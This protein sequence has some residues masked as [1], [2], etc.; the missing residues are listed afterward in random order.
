VLDA[1][2]TAVFTSATMT[3]AHPNPNLD[4]TVPNG[5]VGRSV[6]LEFSGLETAHFTGGIAEFS[7]T[8]KR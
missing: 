4:L 5:V 6:V 3:L 1:S 7:V 8:G 2:S